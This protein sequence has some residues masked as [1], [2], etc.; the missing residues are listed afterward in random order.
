MYLDVC[1]LVAAG[2]WGVDGTSR[3]WNLD[4]GEVGHSLGVGSECS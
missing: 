3:I 1:F 2:T 4:G